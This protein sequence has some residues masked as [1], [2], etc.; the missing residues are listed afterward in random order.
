MRTTIVLDD[1]LVNEALALTGARSKRRVVQI[2]LL[3]LVKSR[4]KKNLPDL[5]GQIRF[6]DRYDYMTTRIP[7]FG[8]LGSH[9]GVNLEDSAALLE[10]METSPDS[11]GRQRTRVH[12]PRRRR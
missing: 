8:G 5:A 3:E 1:H 12:P 10:L 4:K 9:P 11:D 7:T 2:A 6:R